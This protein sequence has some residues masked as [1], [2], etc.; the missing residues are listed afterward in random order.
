MTEDF[1]HYVW[2]GSNFNTPTLKGL[3]GEIIEIIRPGEHNTD[4]GPDFSNA[5]IRVNEQLWA[6]NV[7]IHVRSSDWNK[8]G[9]QNDKAYQNVILH[10]VYEHD[11]EVQLFNGK[12][13]VPTLVIEDRFDENLYWKYERFLQS[14][15][16]IPCD[17]QIKFV[18]KI[19]IENQLEVSLVERLAHKTKLIGDLLETNKGD[20]NETFYQWMCRGFGLKVNAEPMLMLARNLDQKT[21]LKYADDLFQIEA[22][23]F[24]SSGL[25]VE[26]LDDYS[27]KLAREFEY[28][29]KKHSLYQ[30]EASIWKFSRIRPMAFP[31]LRLAQFASLIH[32]S[33]TLFSRVMETGRIEDL[34]SLI[35]VEVSS[36]WQ[37]HYRF[38]LAAKGSTGGIGES[39]VD[40]L[41]IN[42]IVPFMFIYGSLKGEE[43]YKQR[44]M[45]LLD[46][47]K[48]EDNKISRYYD[49]LGFPMETAFHSQATIQL[50]ENYCKPKKCLNCKLGTYLMKN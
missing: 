6:G 4:A 42:V 30:M 1:L 14:G 48:P 49:Q 29:Q 19:H 21:L 32:H 25:V 26:T 41:V 44:A 9:H 2:K 36:Y 43:F 23:L 15:E 13:R 37:S 11:K 31:T 20:W 47:M 3:K 45:D 17:N 5:L 10:V 35:H 27:G 12:D 33:H 38:G 28:L 16:T 18:P 22:L 8:H 40:T 7:E 50:K 46:Q 39:F 24:G 34:R